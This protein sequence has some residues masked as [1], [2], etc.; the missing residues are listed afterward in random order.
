MNTI[1]KEQERFILVSA[2][3]KQY[4][5]KDAW[6]SLD[7]LEEL[8]ET[9]NGIVITKI[10]QRLDHIHTATYIG[11]G[12]VEEIKELAYLKDASGLVFD[13]ELSPVQM[14]NL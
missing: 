1:E 10:L 13:D 11:S 3:K 14:R 8:V 6:E 9:A 4:D 2:Q 7:E 12:K 5:E